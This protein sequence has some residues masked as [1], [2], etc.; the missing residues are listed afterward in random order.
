MSEQ[1]KPEFTKLTTP[2]RSRTYH[3]ADTK[4]RAENVAA[5][6]VRQQQGEA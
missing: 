4:I 3:F 1:A 5:V 6:R 2:E